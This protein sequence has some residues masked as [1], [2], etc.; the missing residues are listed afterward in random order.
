M[1]KSIATALA[2]MM[3][4]MGVLSVAPTKIDLN[5]KRPA[6]RLKPSIEMIKNARS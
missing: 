2:G 6:S 3:F 1:I 5:G 4:I